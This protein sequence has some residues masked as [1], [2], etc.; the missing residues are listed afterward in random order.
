MMQWHA[1]LL[2]G[3]QHF[4]LVFPFM[5]F[6][7]HSLQRFEAVWLCAA[8]KFSTTLPPG[9]GFFAVLRPASPFAFGLALKILNV[10]C[11]TTTRRAEDSF[12][13]WVT[14]VNKFHVISGRRSTS[15]LVECWTKRFHDHSFPAAFPR[16]MFFRP[17]GAEAQRS[18]RRSLAR[19][20]I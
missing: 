16:K 8:R 13:V 6:H 9:N 15:A 4:S 5:D 3:Q 14:L 2:K 11:E 1:E 10:K 20:K 19:R 7:F 12:L 18:T 17:H